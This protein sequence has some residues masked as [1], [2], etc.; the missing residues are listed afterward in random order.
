MKAAVATMAS[1]PA[2]KIQFRFFIVLVCAGSE[3]P[4][5][6]LL[7]LDG[8]FCALFVNGYHSL[9]VHGMPLLENVGLRFLHADSDL[10]REFGPAADR[11]SA[12]LA[13]RM[14]AGHRVPAGNQVR[15]RG[16]SAAGDRVA[17]L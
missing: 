4:G 1:A 7:P 6:P 9:T 10:E 12:G 14:R 13:E 16:L 17:W 5:K 15:G 2:N 3:R 11:A 8:E